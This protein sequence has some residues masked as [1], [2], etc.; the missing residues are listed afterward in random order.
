[1]AECITISAPK[2]IGLV[3]TG[4]LTVESTASFA[5]ILFATNDASSISM[6]S[7]V[8]LLGVS[9]NIDFVLPLMAFSS[10]ASGWYGS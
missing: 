4:V 10:N 6:I 7:H 3:K 8:G 2:S 9:N 5:F 1:M